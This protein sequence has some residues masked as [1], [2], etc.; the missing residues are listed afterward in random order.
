MDWETIF[1]IA[2]WVVAFGGA[3]AKVRSLV[4]ALK[5]REGEENG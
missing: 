2:F 4:K 3:V 1:K 5:E